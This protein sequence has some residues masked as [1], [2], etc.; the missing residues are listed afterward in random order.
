MISN[1]ILIDD[2]TRFLAEL[3]QSREKVSF[4]EGLTLHLLDWP[5]RGSFEFHTISM[6]H[7]LEP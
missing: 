6:W 3:E 4:A 5:P 7:L 2:I 1:G